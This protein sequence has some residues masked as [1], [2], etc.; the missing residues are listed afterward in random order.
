MKKKTILSLTSVYALC[1]LL[2]L[3]LSC[4]FLIRALRRGQTPSP[5]PKDTE[6]I[7]IYVTDN[8]ESDSADET[9]VSGWIV[10]EYSEKIGIFTQDGTL[11]QVLD[12]YV[13]TLPETDRRLLGE[14]I[15]IETRAQLNA[16][17][18]DYTG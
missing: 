12:T 17:I 18:E 13:K 2:I 9:E 8:A 16:I 4:V 5:L 15:Y 3:I 10:K 11:V 14:G 6:Y 7:Y 1:M